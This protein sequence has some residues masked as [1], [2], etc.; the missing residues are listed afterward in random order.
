GGTRRGGCAARAFRGCHRHFARSALPPFAGRRRPA[1][2][3]RAIRTVGGSDC[4]RGARHLE[5]HV[6]RALPAVVIRRGG[7]CPPYIIPRILPNPETP[8]L[9]ASSDGPA[10]R[11]DAESGRN[12]G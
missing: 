6:G 8:A 12:A 5:K 7:R 3:R 4:A 2:F 1:S 11:C 9:P 10:R